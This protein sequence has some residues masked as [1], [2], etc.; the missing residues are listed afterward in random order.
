[1]ILRHLARV[2]IL[3]IC[4]ASSTAS[5]QEARK[6][7]TAPDPLT[8][9][10]AD[11]LFGNQTTRSIAERWLIPGFASALPDADTL[12]QLFVI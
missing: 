9:L 8:V 10:L 5:A 11:R 3:S 2:I 4:C 6:T 12:A 1:M 7:G